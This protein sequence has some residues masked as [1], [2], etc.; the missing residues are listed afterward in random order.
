MEQ[1]LRAVVLNGEEL[2][3]ALMVL[4]SNPRVRKDVLGDC[5]CSIDPDLKYRFIT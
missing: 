2:M 3:W 5:H 4:V 1:E